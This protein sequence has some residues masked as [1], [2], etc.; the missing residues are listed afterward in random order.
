[1]MAILL[2]ALQQT[3]EGPLGVPAAPASRGDAIRG[4]VEWLVA[5][6]NKDGSWGSHHSPRPIEV[7]ADVPGS[8]QAFRVATSALC[9]MAL[10]AGPQPTDASRAAHSRGLDYL[11]ADYDVKRPSGMEHYNVWSFGYTLQCFGEHLLAQPADPR[12]E[13]L[14]AASRRLVEKLA[15]YQALDGGWGYLS[16]DEVPT[17][18][19]SFTSMSFTTATCLIGLQRARQAGI[20]VPQA[21]VDKAVA[22]IVRCQTPT[23]S[24]TYGELWRNSPGRGINQLK[25]A[26]CRAPA[27]LEAIGVFGREPSAE[28]CASA[29][30]DLLV[31]N[32]R[33]QV[34]SLRRPIPHESHYQIS[35][36]FYLYGH[37]Y[38]TLLLARVPDPA[39][40]APLLEQAVMICREPDGSFWDYPL[41]SYHKPY[42]TAFALLVLA[43]LGSRIPDVAS[44][45]G[46]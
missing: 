32:A 40:Y 34:A 25:G 2:L 4:A 6:Q 3:L 36:Y 37:Y 19:P 33:F 27:C 8:H 12:A 39:R 13:A 30:D 9:V 43:Q 14:R 18:R 15:L 42:G 28:Q 11:L 24:F 22:S 46:S 38:A 16:L 23:G 17:F 7:L 45:A 1:M 44:A 35:G 26:A 41:Y 5:H 29:L 21:V 20:E 31:R 10:A